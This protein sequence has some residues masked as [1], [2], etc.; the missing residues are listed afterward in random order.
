M[1]GIGSSL[2][3]INLMRNNQEI[4]T[5]RK[6]ILVI[7]RH[8]CKYTCLFHIGLIRNQELELLMP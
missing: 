2:E 1:V 4:I 8:L 6:K 5:V 7:A 3:P